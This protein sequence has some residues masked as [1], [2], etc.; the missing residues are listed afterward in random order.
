MIIMSCY[1]FCIVNLSRVKYTHDRATRFNL[2]HVTLAVMIIGSKVCTYLFPI[3]FFSH[4]PL[5]FRSSDIACLK[6]HAICISLA[7]CS[8]ASTL[9]VLNRSYLAGKKIAWQKISAI[10][11]AGSF[12]WLIIRRFV[13][14]LACPAVL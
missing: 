4:V 7:N 12:S 11:P 3:F 1:D 13:I 10:L 9:R 2:A 6:M 8:C 5:A 14:I